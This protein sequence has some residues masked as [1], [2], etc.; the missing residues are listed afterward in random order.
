[1]H[2][3]LPGHDPNPH[4]IAHV[5]HFSRDFI[6]N[7]DAELKRANPILYLADR[8]Y[9]FDLVASVSWTQESSAKSNL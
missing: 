5:C 8:I 4:P 1:V 9:F 2:P 7:I 3:H 6:A